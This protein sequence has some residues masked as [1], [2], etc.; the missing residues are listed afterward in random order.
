[1]YALG[2]MLSKNAQGKESKVR[3]LHWL[4]EARKIGVDLRDGIIKSLQAMES[5]S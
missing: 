2:F 5:G 3:A 1:M 4:M